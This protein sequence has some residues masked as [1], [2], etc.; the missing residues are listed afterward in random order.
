MTSRRK[1]SAAMRALALQYRTAGMTCA[2]CGV[3]F[4]AR[5]FK[6]VN[7]R[8]RYCSNTCKQR[9]KRQRRAGNSNAHPT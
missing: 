4:E 9:A 2:V 7:T 5:E 8:P 6:S 3:A 1:S